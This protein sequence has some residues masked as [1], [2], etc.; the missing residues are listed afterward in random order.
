[1]YSSNLL[2]TATMVV[3][4]SAYRAL[5]AVKDSWEYTHT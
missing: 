1:M 2:I 5:C 3:E 4:N